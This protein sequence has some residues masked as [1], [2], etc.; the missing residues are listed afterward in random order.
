MTGDIM[1][2]KVDFRVTNFED[3]NI[4]PFRDLSRHYYDVH[5]S[6]PYF[7]V[8]KQ[9]AGPDRDCTHFIPLAAPILYRILWYR[10]L[11]RALENRAEQSIF[12]Q[13]LNGP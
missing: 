6:S 10:I 5:Y 1:G 12:K 2:R 8:V 3:K 9:K 13:T 4:I 7:R 11:V